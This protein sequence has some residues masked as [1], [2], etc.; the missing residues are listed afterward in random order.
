MIEIDEKK[1]GQDLT[2]I[3]WTYKPKDDEDGKLFDLLKRISHA[4]LVNRNGVC[5]HEIISGISLNEEE[6]KLIAE[7]MLMEHPNTEVRTRCLDVMIRFA[8]GRDRIT[9]MRQASDGYLSLYKETGI[10]FYFIRAIEVRKCKV[11]YDDAFMNRMRD[12]IV[13]DKIHPGWMVDALNQVKTNLKNGLDDPHMK[14]ILVSYQDEVTRRDAH[15][16]DCH[17]NMLHGIGS[18]SEKEWHYQK[19]LNWEKYA[20]YVEANKKENVFNA[21]LHMILR[22]GY[23][24]IHHIKDDYPEDYKRIRDKYNYAKKDFVAA[25]SLF[26]VKTKIEVPQNM[27]DQI[28]KHVSAISL[29]SIE[30]A[31]V[32]YLKIPFFPAWEE[33]VNKQVKQSIKQSGVI[34]RSFPNGQTLDS[35][36]NVTG[37]FNFERGHHLQ[38]HRCIRASLMYYVISSYE[39][40]REH[41][42]DYSE[43]HFYKILKACKPT[44]IED[45]RI[46]LWAKAYY[47]YFKGDIVIASHLLMP[48]FEHALHNLLEEIVEDVTKLNA[49][50]QKEPTLIGILNQLKPYCNPTL[51][52]ELFFY[53][54]DGNDVNYRNRLLHGLMWSMEMLQ[55]GHYLFYLSNLLFFEGK[56]FLKIGG[57]GD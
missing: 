56:G 16:V 20:D 1:Y 11:L 49:V 55:Y 21:N 29:D 46:Q 23:M 24:E 15:W 9:R 36:G 39:R 25:M 42:L 4:W 6:Q 51:F 32:L 54:V 41:S 14:S 44:H 34:E 5:Q 13:N 38:V 22:D 35:E 47:Y 40:V 8:K 28:H 53:L 17:W 27:I 52:D 18:I 26:G 57:R 37:V 10:V 19:A 12:V 43:G 3:F 31:I 7:N 48:Q 50:I 33:L 2:G 45:D 30:E